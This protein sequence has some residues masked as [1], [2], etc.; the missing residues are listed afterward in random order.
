M[1]QPGNSAMTF[2]KYFSVKAKSL[3]NRFCAHVGAEDMDPPR[4]ITAGPHLPTDRNIPS[5]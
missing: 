4:L 2:A 3:K 1:K 5:P